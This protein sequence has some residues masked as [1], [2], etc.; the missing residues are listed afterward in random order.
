MQ[1]SNPTSR[2][3]CTV[4]AHDTIAILDYGSQTSQ[5]IAR[6]LRERHVYCELIPWDAPAERFASLDRAGLHPLRRAGQRLRAGRADPAAVRPGRGETDLGHLLRY[7][8]AGLR[9]RRRR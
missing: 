6:R 4:S 1:I 9:P 5:L 2:K 3:R 8:T 7:A